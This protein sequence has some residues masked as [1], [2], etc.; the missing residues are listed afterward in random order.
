MRGKCN[1]NCGNAIKQRIVLCIKQRIVLRI[2]QALNCLENMR[3]KGGNIME[4]Q[5]IL[6]KQLDCIKATQYMVQ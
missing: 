1:W 6:N 2:C 5:R 3:V 4:L